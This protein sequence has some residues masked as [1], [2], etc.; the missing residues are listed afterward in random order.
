KD[1]GLPELAPL[2][3]LVVTPTGSS[4]TAWRAK[5]GKIC[6]W[7]FCAKPRLWHADNKHQCQKNHLIKI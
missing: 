4:Q 6:S 2:P 7:M 5:T 3:G 1:R